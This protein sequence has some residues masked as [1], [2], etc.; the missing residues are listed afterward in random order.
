MF[1]TVS[2]R[3]CKANGKKALSFIGRSNWL[4]FTGARS[5]ESPPRSLDMEIYRKGGGMEMIF[6]LI[7]AFLFDLYVP[8]MASGDTE[9]SLE[10]VLTTGLIKENPRKRR[11]EDDEELRGG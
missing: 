7:S 3:F 11:G 5:L 4:A 8:G 10:S 6:I 2:F 1:S 9:R